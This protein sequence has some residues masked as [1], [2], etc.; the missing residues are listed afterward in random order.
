MCGACGRGPVV[1]PWEIQAHGATV[2]HHRLRAAEA[3]R[4]TGGRLSVKP[5]GPAGYVV[6]ARTGGQ[7]VV[8]D[9]DQLAVV[10]RAHESVQLLRRAAEVNEGPSKTPVAAAIVAEVMKS[11]I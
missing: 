8:E 10:L 6:R 11:I 7:S 5:F 1:A 9:V 4:L 2:R 3:E